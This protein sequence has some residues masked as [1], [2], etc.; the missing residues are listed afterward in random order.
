MSEI[1]KAIDYFLKEN[2]NPILKK[3]GFK[4]NGRRYSRIKE[5][6]IDSVYI[7]SLRW[8]QDG[9]GSFTVGLGIY[10]SEIAELMGKGINDNFPY[11]SESGVFID[12]G[13]LLPNNCQF[14]WDVA[15]D[16]SNIEVGCELQEAIHMAALPWFEGMMIEDN[17][18]DFLESQDSLHVLALYYKV[19]NKPDKVFH[20]VER[21][22]KSDTFNSGRVD[23]ESWLKKM[24][25]NA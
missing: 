17:L 5:D 1:S 6:R 20:Y 10:F 14:G 11:G 19:Q 3:E 8:N 2:L 18:I 15:V 9:F 21:M 7:E 13:M 22:R 24:G 23:I 25:I 12:I 16:D 4:E